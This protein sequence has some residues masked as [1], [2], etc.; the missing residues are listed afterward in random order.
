MDSLALGY[1]GVGWP[2]GRRGREVCVFDLGFDE[3]T[4]V[5]VHESPL[6]IL[7]G[8]GHVDDLPVGL[9]RV[10]VVALETGHDVWLGS[11]VDVDLVLLGVNVEGDLNLLGIQSSWLLR[12]L[13]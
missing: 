11:A 8:H 7:G 9:D 2:L 12:K 10:D 6:L 1:L 4:L 13:G 3:V 5:S